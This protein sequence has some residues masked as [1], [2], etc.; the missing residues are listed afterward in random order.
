M[1]QTLERRHG[2]HPGV[3]LNDAARRVPTAHEPRAL[4]VAEVLHDFHPDRPEG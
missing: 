1:M 2:L 4:V 3:E